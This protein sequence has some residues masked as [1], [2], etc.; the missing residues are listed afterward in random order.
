MNKTIT[1]NIAGIVFHIDENA[2]HKLEQY[3]KNIRNYFAGSE[4]EDDIVSGIEERIADMFQ[5]RLKDG[6][7]V[8]T[9]VEVDEVIAIMGQPEAFM[10]AE[11]MDEQ[12]KASAKAKSTN[13]R[14][15]RDPDNRVVGGVCSGISHYLGI[16]DPV[17]LRLALLL[18]VVFAGTGILLYIILW[19]VIP[20]AKTPTEKLEMKGEN[21]NVE[22]IGKTVNAEFEALRNKWDNSSVG[23]NGAVRQISDFL[24]RAITLVAHI[25]LS[26]VKFIAKLLGLM[27]LLFGAFAFMG[28]AAV[29]LS[30]LPWMSLTSE[31]LMTSGMVNGLL[32]N[33]MGGAM[34]AAL[35][36][37]SFFF[38]AGI[39]MLAIA[40]LGVKLLFNFR[41]GTK[42][43]ALAFGTLWSIGL[44]L[45]IVTTARVASDFAAEG[46]ST[47]TITLEFAN[48][49]DKSPIVLALDHSWGENEPT[50][51]VEVFG[52]EILVA[53]GVMSIYGK[54][55]FNV[56]KST[57]GKIELV[58]K[59]EA[60]AGSR[61][62]ASKLANSIDYGFVK[63]D[64]SLLLNGFFAIP[65]ADK[66]RAQ[67]VELELQIPVGTTILLTEEM[68]RI[69]YDIKNVTDTY[70]GHMV[71]RRWKMTEKGLACVD[72]EGL[73]NEETSVDEVV[74]EDIYEDENG[75]VIE[76]RVT[77]QRRMDE[78]KKELEEMELELKL[79]MKEKEKGV[80]TK[81]V[82]KKVVKK[83]ATSDEESDASSS[84]SPKEIIL[85]RVVKA[86]YW[87][88][89]QTLRSIT[90]TALPG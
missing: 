87:I 72:C 53:D 1:S 22:N 77:M 61:E 65:D 37:V 69:I 46:D 88:D 42:W 20:S 39:P 13:K 73:D 28:I 60:H 48:G 81:K 79:Q 86:S 6:K 23:G 44:I 54:P 58:M 70:D 33:V 25:L 47:E 17:W 35:A 19:I 45:A 16:T 59:R 11:D 51:E 34:N 90:M 29:S 55:E 31:G 18:A 83:E 15:F 89:P 2:F 43:V 63:T 27:F 78:K 66:W 26:I 71:G 40:F 76:R 38:L 5:A 9:M 32:E 41:K 8:V 74:T 67:D 10:D 50:E 62:E 56:T 57:T 24:V 4:G 7:S 30:F 52:M 68:E 64:T 12:P 84:I 85:K 21:V 3:L 80:E 49:T 14:I 75:R 82:E 36:K